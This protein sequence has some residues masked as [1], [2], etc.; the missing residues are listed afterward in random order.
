MTD[1]QDIIDR[2]NSL[3]D[4][5]SEIELKR[6]S[7]LEERKRQYSSLKS[8]I[9]EKVVDRGIGLYDDVDELRS[10]FSDMWMANYSSYDK[11]QNRDDFIL[12]F[13]KVMSSVDV[14]HAIVERERC[15]VD[16]NQNMMVPDFAIVVSD[17]M[18]DAEMKKVAGVVEKILVSTIDAIGDEDYDFTVVGD[19][20]HV[21]NYIN[22]YVFLGRYE[23][24]YCIGN[25]FATPDKLLYFDTVFDALV[26]LRDVFHTEEG[27]K[28]FD[29][30]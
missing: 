8:M 23:G 16:E 2:I 19:A 20:C 12:P 25:S 10:V 15:W 26:S 27:K 17:D 5:L 21:H 29:M 3:S 4:E 9:V 24:K 6:N 13:N 22:N 7:L 18:T 1:K 30:W 11:N 14:G 28:F